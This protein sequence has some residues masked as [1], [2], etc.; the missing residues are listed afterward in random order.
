VLVFCD[1]LNRAE[2]SRDHI[3]QDLL[4]VFVRSVEA[5]SIAIRAAGGTI[6]YVDHDSVCA[7]FGLAGT[8]ERAARQALR[9]AGMIEQALRELNGRLGRQWA[10]KAKIVVSIHAGRAIIGEVGGDGG[11]MMAV[12]NALEVAMQLRT[13]L[14]A[15]DKSFGVSLPVISASR[16]EVP[17]DGFEMIELKTETGS[18]VAYLSDSAPRL[19]Q[20]S[21]ATAPWRTVIDRASGLAQDMMRT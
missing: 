6:S 11:A 2:L 14:A 16:L 15:K 8:S 12:G 10:C 21:R 20:D 9:A 1:F 7:L 5:V 17:S 4:F 13:A 19:P 18:V 3:A